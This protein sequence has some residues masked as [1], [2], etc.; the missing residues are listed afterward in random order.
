[1][2]LPLAGGSG[3]VIKLGELV[4]ILELH[5]QGL[6]VS[7][8][9]RQLGLDRKTVRRYIER[10]LEPPTYG[11]RP[12]QPRSTDRFLPYLRERLAAY[13][14]LTA[15]RLWREL[16]ER[17]YAGGYTAV[18]RTVREIRPEPI[19]PFDA[20]RRRPASRPRSISPASRSRSPMNPAPRV[21]SGYSRWYLAIRV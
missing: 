10:G 5:R 8:I 18:K 21:S 17:G 20:S 6:K 1:M 2:L 9:A 12:P 14:G 11:P 4:M 15:V 16:R 13:P 19:K 3:T 7:A